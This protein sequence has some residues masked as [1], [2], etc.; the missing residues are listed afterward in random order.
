MNCAKKGKLFVIAGHSGVGKGTLVALLREKNPEIKLSVSV[1]TRKPRP[2]EINGVSYFFT[3][4]ETFHEMVKQGCFLEWAEFAG[5][6]YGTDKEIVEKNLAK[7]QDIILEI[8]VQ[9]ALQVTDKNPEAVLIFIESPSFEELKSR[10]LGRK[11][12]SEQDIQKR[13]SVVEFELAQKNRFNYSIVNDNLDKAFIELENIIK[14][15][16]VKNDIIR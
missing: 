4:K 14:Q 16:M 1:T 15:E 3:E 10:L 2:G 9:G 6:C 12:E 13:L 8:D 7:G 11:T 5:N